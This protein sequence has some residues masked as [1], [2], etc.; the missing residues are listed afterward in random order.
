MDYLFSFHFFSKLNL[1]LNKLKII[2]GRVKCIWCYI[3]YK[4]GSTAEECY[5]LV[6]AETPTPLPWVSDSHVIELSNRVGARCGGN[7]IKPVVPCLG[8]AFYPVFETINSIC[9]TL[10]VTRVFLLSVVK[11]FYLAASL[12]CPC[13]L[14]LTGITA[15]L[16]GAKLLS[17]R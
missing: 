5:F 11:Y 3:T 10:R 15:H 17:T 13:T 9:V 1:T 4:P 16:F 6:W 8:C 2:G 7:L 12:E 14:L